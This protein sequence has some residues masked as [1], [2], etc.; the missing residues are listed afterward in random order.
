MSSFVTLKHRV[1]YISCDNNKVDVK[2]LQ[3]SEEEMLAAQETSVNMLIELS[4]LYSEQ[5]KVS[6]FSF[7][8]NASKVT[9]VDG[10]NRG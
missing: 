2:L 10:K 7:V 8:Q 9:A 3:D 1:M 4:E 6:A 5:G